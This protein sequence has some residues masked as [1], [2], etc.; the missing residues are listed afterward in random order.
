MV[1][2]DPRILRWTVKDLTVAEEL[3]RGGHVDMLLSA[4]YQIMRWEDLRQT[5]G[6]DSS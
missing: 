4:L 6:L 2:N 3:E 1:D 5:F